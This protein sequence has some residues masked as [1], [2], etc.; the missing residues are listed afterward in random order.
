MDSATVKSLARETGFDLAGIAAPG[1]TLES[2]FYP[3]WLAAGFHGEMSYLEGRRGDLRAAAH[4]LLPSAKSVI[5]LG[6]IY[7]TPGPS[8]SAVDTET[9]GWVSRYAWGEDYHDVIR[10]LLYELV[11]RIEAAAGPFDSKVCVDTAPLLERAYA[12]HAGLGWIGKNTC[13]INQQIGSW[14]FLGE[15][16]TSLELQPDDPAP[17]RCG[18]CTRCI[19]ACPTDALVPVGLPDGPS[20]ALD[21]T[22]CISYWTIELRGP[23]PRED[24]ASLGPHI[25]GCDICQD[26]CPWNR[27]TPAT[28]RPEFQPM[29][30]LPELAELAQLTEQQFNERF[31][32]SPIERARYQGFLRN[33]TVAMGNSGNRDFLPLLERLAANPDALIGEHAQWAIERITAA[34]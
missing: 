2:L 4:E 3:E 12:H 27:R 33:V 34:P 24:R 28:D 16:L 8:T 7:D 29:H 1:P 31:A 26:V 32:L 22:K 18:T 25:F 10:K 6:L 21:A 9:Q 15:I 20:H 13:L 11:E 17:F 5:S 30:M 23:I 14:V 19:D